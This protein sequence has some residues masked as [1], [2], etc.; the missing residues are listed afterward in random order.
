VHLIGVDP[1]L[2]VL[3]AA[4]EFTECILWDIGY[5]NVDQQ[6]LHQI[7]SIVA[8]LA[9]NRMLPAIQ[10]QNFF[11]WIFRVGLETQLLFIIR[12]KSPVFAL[13]LKQCLKEW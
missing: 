12:A 10:I 7:F 8:Y 1:K 2:V 9:S 6:S 13:V 4:A 3:K 5:L 11:T